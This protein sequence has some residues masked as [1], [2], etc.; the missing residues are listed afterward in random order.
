MTIRIQ[1]TEEQW[2][3]IVPMWEQICQWSGEQKPGMLLA[4]IYDHEMVVGT[5]NHE[6]GRA[7]RMALGMHLPK[8]TRIPEDREKPKV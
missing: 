5:I 8:T 1:L 6:K 2:E 3:Q 4:Q 7:V